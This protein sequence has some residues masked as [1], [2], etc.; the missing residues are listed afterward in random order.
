MDSNILNLGV[1]SIWRIMKGL[2]ATNEESPSF[3]V[4][5]ALCLV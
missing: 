3:E 5:T 1:S 2:Q 4:K